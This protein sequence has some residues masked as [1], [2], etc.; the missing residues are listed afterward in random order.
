[1]KDLKEKIRVILSPNFVVCLFGI[2][3]ILIS[4]I[5]GTEK[6]SSVIMLSVGAS[7]IASCVILFVNYISCANDDKIYQIYQDWGLREIYKTRAEIN[8][9]T[10]KKLENT[11]SLE[12]CAMG[13]KSFRDAQTDLIKKKV[14]NGMTI[15]IVTISPESRYTFEI[16]ETEKVNKGST[17]E[18]IID[19]IQWIE[20]LK[21][22]QKY[23]G[24]I[25][26]RTY[27]HYP[28]QFYF[29]VD[30]DIF[31]G[32]YQNKTSQQTITYRFYR[33][34]EGY[35][36]YKKSFDDLWDACRI[37]KQGDRK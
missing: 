19:L 23:D 37:V 4:V 12:I 34:G 9:Y 5:N 1:M 22:F 31:I 30:D 28:Y 25:E 29:R 36:Y 20:E 6:V 32:P 18:T 16:D 15:K 14:A 26:L 8:Q 2:I 17:Y 27:D 33:G 13:L 7:I 11:N 10:N 35:N 21:K 3:L 24:Q